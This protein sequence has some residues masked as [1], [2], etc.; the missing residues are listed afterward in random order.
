MSERAELLLRRA[1]ECERSGKLLEANDAYLR[2]LRHADEIEERQEAERGAAR[3]SRELDRRTPSPV[4]CAK[5]MNKAISL[6]CYGRSGTHFL[7]SLLDGHPQIV[8]TMLDGTK[9]LELW[10][11]KLKRS[12]PLNSDA[13]ADAVMEK[14]PFEFNEGRVYKEPQLNG[15]CSMGESKDY[16][17][18]IDRIRFR[19]GLRKFLGAE[20]APDAKL[21]YQAV[22]L[23]AAYG[24]GRTYDFRKGIPTIV[25]GGI[26]FG[27]YIQETERL[28]ALFPDLRLLYMVRRP[29]IAFASALKFQLKSGQAN[30]YNLC[31][32]LKLVLQHTPAMPHWIDRTLAI[33][34]EDLHRGPHTILKSLCDAL[35]LD[36]S[37]T[38]LGSTF[39]GVKWWNT[40]TSAAVSGFNTI[41]TSNEY[42]ELL[43]DED[44]KRLERFL[45]RKYKAW[46]Y[47]DASPAEGED[48]QELLSVPFKFE[49]QYGGNPSE[50]GT[51]RM[52]IRRIL[53]QF[54]LEDRAL[55]QSNADLH[56]VKP[57]CLSG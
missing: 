8:L 41:T 49:A 31:F 29:D 57:I 40:T 36:W 10:E 37:D 9:L 23:A 55:D 35:D 28:L 53:S 11:E 13:I 42:G 25:E 46:G 48:L 12:L 17:F 19:E 44:K 18:R 6:Y 54:A 26:H 3:M 47:A 5:S 21:F 27:L 52:M 30:I 45:W 51:N 2:A 7:K 20:E 16:V 32:Q 34:L 39:G 1:G 38:L 43:S 24:L 56:Q 15:M 33:R 50:L 14:L 4:E 22:Q